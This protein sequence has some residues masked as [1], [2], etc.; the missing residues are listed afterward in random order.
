MERLPRFVSA[1]VCF[2]SVGFEKVSP[3]LRRKFAMDD[4]RQRI[5]RF[6]G[7]QHIQFDEVGFAVAR[8][9]VVER[10]VAA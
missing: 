8:E 2:V 3:T 6:A 5:D 7:D 10:S 1:V 4:Q 9:V